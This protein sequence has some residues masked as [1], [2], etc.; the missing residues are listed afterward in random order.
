MQR[1]R[2]AALVLTAL[3]AG[4]G[5]GAVSHSA[6]PVR[7]QT[8]SVAFHIEP[9]K[10]PSGAK[11][12]PRYVSLGT[13]SA[14]VDISSAG[15]ATTSKIIRCSYGSC[16]GSLDAPI[17]TDTF[18]VTLYDGY[19]ADGNV[20]SA[21]KT[22]QTIIANQANSVNVTF[23][24]VPV[25]VIALSFGPPNALIGAPSTTTVNVAAVDAAGYAIIGPGAYDPPIK[26]TLSDPSG[27]TSL[28]ETTVTAPN[29]AVKLAY[30]GTPKISATVTAVVQGDA[31]Q[32]TRVFEPAN[33]S[34]EF[35][36]Q[37]PDG[38]DKNIA[39]K[40]IV[41]GADGAMWFVEGPDSKIGRI[42]GT[43]AITEY[44]I[45]GL[46]TSIIAGPDGALWFTENGSAQYGRIATDGS[47][48]EHAI[49]TGTSAS[50]AGL[51]F[52]ADGNLYVADNGN[53]AV[54]AVTPATGALVQAYA[55]PTNANAIVSGPDG[56]VW[57]GTAGAV[58]RIRLS[59]GVVSPFATSGAITSL[60]AGSD[61]NVWFTDRAGKV[62]NV[63]PAGAV[64]EF[65]LPHF[66]D[67][68]YKIVAAPD[69]TYWFTYGH[70]P[71]ADETVCRMGHA[72]AS[73]S[74]TSFA[75]ADCSTMSLAFGPDHNL[76]L[77]EFSRSRIGIF[78]SF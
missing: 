63:T 78:S 33:V 49:A 59:D 57:V 58:A 75:I 61:G 64:A 37:Y 9:S 3:F 44:A 4:C 29:D 5:S 42:S 51:A 30:N 12:S 11:R 27:S 53:A 24:A 8:A 66:G 62:G 68:A 38:S 48:S 31:V 46:P 23:D 16:S 65:A 34:K 14:R 77:A 13:Q 69:G 50:A 60:A 1:I 74:V 6:P 54:Y 18:T 22:T 7:L 56:N 52:G 55:L 2:G 35:T 32:V 67:D 72:T 73:G 15:V 71:P 19:T 26:L 43:G 40:D 70:L 41:Q 47:L 45:A 20:L 21:G 17:A 39:P 76:W 10:A 28:S 25:H 36:L